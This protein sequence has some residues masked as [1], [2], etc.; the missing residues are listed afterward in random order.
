MGDEADAGPALGFHL[1]EVLEAGE[2]GSAIGSSGFGS[3]LAD[4]VGGTD[5]IHAGHLHGL[6]AGLC[7]GE[8]GE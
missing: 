2:I 4:G 1:V 7:V 8:H 6:G 5:V 3:L